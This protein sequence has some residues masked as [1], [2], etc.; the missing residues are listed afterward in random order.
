MAEPVPLVIYPNLERKT[1]DISLDDEIS[2]DSLADGVTVMYA[3][4]L[5]GVDQAT[6]FASYPVTL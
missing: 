5:D 1:I 2:P 3:P 4:A 6:V